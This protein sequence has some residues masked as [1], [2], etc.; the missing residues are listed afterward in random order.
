MDN[1]VDFTTDLGHQKATNSWS[2]RS[3]T[4]CS[5]ASTIP[6]TTLHPSYQDRRSSIFCYL[7]Q[8][9]THSDPSSL[10]KNFNHSPYTSN[11]AF[12]ALLSS[13]GADQTK[14]RDGG[15]DMGIGENN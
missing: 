1:R 4:H 9:F 8:T 12:F 10:D 6:D 14:R 3:T 13:G 7:S 5:Y 11:L 15:T 2:H